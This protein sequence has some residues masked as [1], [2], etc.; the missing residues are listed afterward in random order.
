MDHKISC[1]N[2]SHRLQLSNDKQNVIIGVIAAFI[3][4]L[5]LQPTL[6]WKNARAQKLPFSL[7]P[8]IIYRGTIAS[9]FN[10]CNMMGLQFGIT[11]YLQSNVHITSNKY[12]NTFLSASFGGAITAIIVSPVELIMIQQQLHGRSFFT[13]PK[14]VIMEHGWFSKGLMRGLSANIARDA[15][16]VS[17]MLA[18]TPIAQ[19]YLIDKYQLHT[20]TA[21]F[22]A[23][24]IGGVI[25]AILSHPFDILKTCMQGD[26]NQY[27]YK[28]YQQTFSSLWKQGGMVRIY[29]GGL[30]R[31][32]N[33]V[34]TVYIANECRMHLPHLLF[35]NNNSNS[36]KNLTN[37]TRFST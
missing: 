5:I 34:G 33:I 30:W 2:V 24:I 37:N 20:Q 8:K 31:T 9:I 17:G 3:E 6:Y 11:G 19:D 36:N 12:I 1:T 4:T 16:Y 29:H 10:E 27:E 18:V 26:L 32:I 25:G 22:Y 15:I 28:T 7:N 13:V 21:G 23:S 35:N 14:Q